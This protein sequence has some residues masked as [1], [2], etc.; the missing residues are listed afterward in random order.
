MHLVQFL[1]EHSSTDY[2]SF[3]TIVACLR[4][5]STCAVLRV[6]LCCTLCVRAL[7]RLSGLR[8][9]NNLDTVLTEASEVASAPSSQCVVARQPR[10]Q[11]SRAALFVPYE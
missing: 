1:Y 7:W 9:N 10:V 3:K 11:C 2:T 8:S 4:H 6:Y 5:V